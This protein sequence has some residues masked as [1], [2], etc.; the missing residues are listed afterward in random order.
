MSLSI[1]ITEKKRTPISLDKANLLG[2]NGTF[3][4]PFMIR[5]YNEKIWRRV[6]CTS[7]A[8]VGSFWVRYKGTKVRINV[9]VLKD[10]K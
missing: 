1:N 8:N 4:T 5:V 10:I 9:N 2:N 6:Y 3:H 7:W